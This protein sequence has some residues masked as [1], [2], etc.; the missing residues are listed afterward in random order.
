MACLKISCDDLSLIID[1]ISKYDLSE[2]SLKNQ[3]TGEN[4]NTIIYPVRMHKKRISITAEFSGI[5]YVFFTTIAKKSE[6]QCVCKMPYDE[7]SGIFTITS[8]ISVMKIVPK[9]PE[10]SEIYA[11]SFTLEEV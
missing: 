8:D 5:E 3:Y 10:N 9:T 11:V 4:G 2:F 7:L 1:K 6:F